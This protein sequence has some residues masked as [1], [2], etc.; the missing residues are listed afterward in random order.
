MRWLTS[1]EGS[2]LEF[3]VE[4][5]SPSAASI[6]IEATIGSGSKPAPALVL[7]NTTPGWDNDTLIT[8]TD[9]F[10]DLREFELI[11]RGEVT[12]VRAT[13]LVERTSRFDLFQFQTS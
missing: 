4:L 12:L 5:I 7:Q 10:S 3:G 1:L 2:A 9:T 11:E 8:L 6:T 13:T